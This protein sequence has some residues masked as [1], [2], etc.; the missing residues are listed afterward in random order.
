[1]YKRKAGYVE[2]Y[3]NLLVDYFN[4]EN[5]FLFWKG[6]VAL[7]AILKAMRLHPG[8]EVIL[9]GFTCVVVPNAILYNKLIPVYVDIKK[10]DLTID[11]DLIERSITTRTKVIIIQNIFGYYSNIDEIM[12]ISKR[13]G[14]FVVEDCAHG[15]GW[16]YNGKKNGLIAD[17]SFFST[18]WN[19]SFSTGIGGFAV[20]NNKLIVSNMQN[21]YDDAVKPNHM[22]NIELFFLLLSKKILLNRYTYWALV[23][24]F[25]WLSKIG[26]ING[27]SSDLEVTSSAEPEKYFKKI[28]W[29][30]ARKGIC[31]LEKVNSHIA[32]RR[33][34]AEAISD[35][36][37]ENGKRYIAKKESINHSFLRYPALVK[38]QKRIYD[39]CYKEKYR[40]WRLV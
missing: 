37:R 23:Y 10:D 2:K 40:Y 15:F 1:M 11:V 24:I 39:D 9:P 13:Y 34:N 25:R 14:L 7:Y 8:D 27:S 36:L 33:K 32:R 29:V 18:Q 20:V 19:K 22:E 26:I 6:R 28:G 4:N 35:F 38:K 31:E 5:V 16:T 12:S 3:K 30:Q 21:D 17:A